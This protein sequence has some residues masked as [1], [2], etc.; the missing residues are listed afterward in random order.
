GN[1]L[2]RELDG[3]PVQ[4]GVYDAQDRL[5]RYGT[6]TTYAEYT[7]TANGDLTEKTDV[8]PSTQQT[9]TYGYDAFGNLRQVGFP[10]G[11]TLGYVI[12]PLNR[13]V[14]KTRQLVGQAT[15][16]LEQG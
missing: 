5:L 16:T 14:G 1:R 3:I 7:Y 10:D 13:R 4:A 12:D 6:A 15:P 11:T 8:T 2:Q 9:T